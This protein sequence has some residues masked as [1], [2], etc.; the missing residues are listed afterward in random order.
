MKQFFIWI[1]VKGIDFCVLNS[2]GTETFIWFLQHSLLVFLQVFINSKG[3]VYSVILLLASVFLTVRLFENSIFILYYACTYCNLNRSVFVCT[4]TE[5]APESLEAGPEVRPLAYVPVCYL[6][7]L[8]HLLSE[9]LD[10]AFHVLL[11]CR[12][13]LDLDNHILPSVTVL[14]IAFFQPWF[15]AGVVNITHWIVTLLRSVVHRALSQSPARQCCHT[16]G[17]STSYCTSETFLLGILSSLREHKS[18]SI[19]RCEEFIQAV[20]NVYSTQGTSSSLGFCIFL[21]WNLI[22]TIKHDTKKNMTLQK[23]YY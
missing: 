5:R 2:R 16:Q 21:F 13:D 11:S 3:L 15:E 17:D 9:T 23:C 20:L 4:G 7:A 12:V 8:L 1:W 14:L 22:I 6:P 10:P 18:V 19:T